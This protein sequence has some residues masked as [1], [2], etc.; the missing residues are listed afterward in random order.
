MQDLEEMLTNAI[1]DELCTFY[2]IL[3]DHYE[4]STSF[5]TYCEI[6][7]DCTVY[8]EDG[9]VVDPTFI[10]N[11]V[12]IDGYQLRLDFENDEEDESWK[13]FTHKMG[14]RK[15]KFGNI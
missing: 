9:R 12:V 5:E 13:S 7:E 15:T 10:E 2:S 6:T 4:D 8:T 3:Q 1:R 11:A 14:A